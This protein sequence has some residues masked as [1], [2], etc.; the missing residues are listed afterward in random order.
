MLKSLHIENIAVIEQTSI[1]LGQGLNVLT[2][3]TGAGKSIVIDAI[4]AI[5][6]ERTSR[7]IVR[8][9]AK[10][11]QVEALFEDVSPQVQEQLEEFGLLPEEDG[12][13]LV[14]RSIS[15]DGKSTCRANGKL[16]TVSM[17]RELG[18]KLIN[19]H[20]QHDNQALLTPE[21]HYVYIDMLHGDLALLNAYKE[22]YQKYVSIERQKK[23][24]QF[25][26]AEKTRQMDLLQY[27]I[28]ELEAA[29]LKIGEK[30]S[31]QERRSA[32]SHSEKIIQS[33]QNAYHSMNGTEEQEGA[34]LLLQNTAVCLEEAARYLGEAR[35]L[36]IELREMSYTLEGAGDELRSLLDAC[37]YDPHELEEIEDRL[38][39]LYQLQRKYGESE[40]EMLEF[41]ESAK[42]KL[43]E[44]E[45]ADERLAELNTASQKAAE[46]VRSLAA[47]LSSLRRK[48]GLAFAEKVQGELAFLDMPNVH[49][50]VSQLPCPITGKGGDQIEFLIS[51]NPGEPPKPIAKIA[52]G[53]ELSR[54]M[55]AI[56]TVLAHNDTIGT[57]IFDEIDTG[58]SGRAAQKIGLKLKQ[59]SRDSQV[60]CVTHSAQVASQSDQHYLIEKGVQNDRTY[61]HVKPLD[62]NGRKY[63]LARIMGGLEITELLL[64]NAEAMLNGAKNKQ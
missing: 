54:I 39:T 35:P 14:Q 42:T 47:K 4:N 45:F 16:I 36:S 57:L 2:G 32:I 58:V 30:V 8:T 44:I 64:Q 18:K 22:A 11:A 37:E 51:T 56:K 50:E 31:L 55:L 61:T 24:L 28:S 12:S 38:D 26:E 7:E 17:L 41:L 20:G 1:D 23:S 13:L 63:E 34:I 27:Q 62:F 48:T 19:I 25:D 43:R 33:L 21:K 40:E 15:S 46:A 5:L 6:G 53:G 59:V 9:G 60:I 49:F 52:S 10:Q 3:E 29:E